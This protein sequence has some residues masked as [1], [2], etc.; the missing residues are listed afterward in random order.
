[1]A[2]F[3]V[4]RGRHYGVNNK[5]IHEVVMLADQYGNP[6][7]GGAAGGTAVDAF[8]RMRTSEPTTLFDSFH[9][10]SDNGKFATLTA[11][12]GTSVFDAGQSTIN[13]NVTGT[14]DSE[15]IRESNRVFAYQPGKSLLI[16][17]SFRFAPLTPGLR[18]RV[19][20]FGLQNGFYLELADDGL[21][22]VARDG[23]ST[24]IGQ[25]GTNTR[26]VQTE[27]NID[28]MDGSGPSG[29]AL[30]LTKVQLMWMDIEWLGVGSV[31]FGFVIDGKFVH[32][33][34]FH[35]ANLI[36]QVYMGTACLPI[37][38]EIKNTLSGSPASLFQVC[39]TVISEGG[40]EIRGD[41]RTT[42]TPLAGRSVTNVSPLP[43]ISLRLRTSPVRLDA[44]SILRTVTLVSNAAGAYEV[45]LV[46]GATL[47][48]TP[49]WSAVGD[50]IEVDIAATGY[51]GG[52]SL[53]SNLVAFTNQNNAAF[54][55]G[56]TDN[57]ALQFERDGLTDTPTIYTISALSDKTNGIA[58]AASV[59]WEDI[60]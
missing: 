40:Y 6:V 14:L 60:T 27:W 21:H 15:V 17:N 35:H 20:Y 44:I 53:V 56:S 12:G 58:L 1:M 51:T 24:P 22:L 2:Q 59:N 37:R 5:D 23:T 3:S 11:N 41:K 39:S 16:M 10:Y 57:F 9:R 26:F 48:G 38:Y 49:S 29:V 19:G 8:G 4:N 47:T 28:P 50:N 54:N 45:K 32:C 7:S 55:L 13:M 30:D 43:L 18:Q 46:K 52:T 31:R 36:S 34:S 42:A 33:H 25:E